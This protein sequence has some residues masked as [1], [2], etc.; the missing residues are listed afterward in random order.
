M[1]KLRQQAGRSFFDDAVLST[2]VAKAESKTSGIPTTKG[3][4][5][6]DVNQL[7]REYRMRAGASGDKAATTMREFDLAIVDPPYGIGAGKQNVSSSKMKGRKNSII[8]R[9]IWLIPIILMTLV[10]CLWVLLVSL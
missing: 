5:T 8:K 6:G 3:Q 1:D 4:Q 9:S 2:S 10:Q 7:A